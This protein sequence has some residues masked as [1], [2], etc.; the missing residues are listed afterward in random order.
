MKCALLPRR[1]RAPP[2]PKK[3]KPL[4]AVKAGRNFEPVKYL[5]SSP[6]G[7]VKR[8]SQTISN[9]SQAALLHRCETAPYKQNNLTILAVPLYQPLL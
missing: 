1:M 4:N 8:Y 3:K 2:P 5:L 6:L 7:L 9:L